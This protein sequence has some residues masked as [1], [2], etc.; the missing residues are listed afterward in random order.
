MRFYCK[1]LLTEVGLTAFGIFL[2][3]HFNGD[4]I[5]CISF[6][7]GKLFWNWDVISQLIIDN[8][9]FLFCFLILALEPCIKYPLTLWEKPFL[10]VT[11]KRAQ[12]YKVGVLR[13]VPGAG[14]LKWVR[15]DLESRDKKWEKPQ[16][17][18]CEAEAGWKWGYKISKVMENLNMNLFAKTPKKL[19]EPILGW[20]KKTLTSYSRQQTR[21]L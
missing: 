21:D 7:D 14:G 16:S 20:L 13:N 2:Y 1:F 4:Y 19:G 10:Y 12:Q 17:I 18:F 9:L 8:V 6:K 15:G 3:P 11:A 5:I